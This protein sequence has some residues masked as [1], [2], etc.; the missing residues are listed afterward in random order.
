VDS[1]KLFCERCALS[2]MQTE[3]NAVLLDLAG[4]EG[5]SVV[6]DFAGGTT[7]SD[8]GALLLGATERVI[9]LV[10]RFS[11]YFLRPAAL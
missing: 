7:T 4:V 11:G 8:G 3:C 2:A 1:G 6:G 10:E 5:R 9:A